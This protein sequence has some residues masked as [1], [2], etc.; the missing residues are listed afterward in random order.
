MSKS[1]QTQ[2]LSLKWEAANYWN[3]P[4]LTETDGSEC[5]QNNLCTANLRWDFKYVTIS[6]H[7]PQVAKTQ[8]YV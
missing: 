8:A 6:A 4:L 3:D 5:F 7:K 1:M 2:K